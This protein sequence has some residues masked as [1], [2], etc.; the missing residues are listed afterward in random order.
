LIE[1]ITKV[2]SESEILRIAK[3]T[4]FVIRES[5]KITA[6]GFLKML[7]YDQL[8]YDNP[9][10]QQHAFGLDAM[11]GIS[12]SEEGL[13]KRFK[14]T[15]VTFIQKIFEAY[16]RHN[17]DHDSIATSLKNKYTAIRVLDSTEFRLP[18][19]LADVF[20]GYNSSSAL[21]CAAI[22]FEYD[23][24][25]RDVCSLTLGNAKQSDKTYAD[26]RMDNINEGELIIRDLGYYSIDSYEKIEDRKA[27]YISR[28][29]S[30]I[31]IYEKHN[32]QYTELDL[33]TLIKRIKK[34]KHT[35]FDQT[36]Y[37]GTKDKKEVRLMAWLLE[38][39]AQKNRLAKKKGRK[40]KINNNDILWSMLNVF[41]TNI[42]KE[43]LTAQEG[44]E[45]YKIR[46]QI[47]LMFKTWKSIL[48]LDLVRKMKADRLKCYL[49]TKLLW[50]LICWDITAIS[51]PIVWSRNKKLIS[52]YKCF[53]LLK[54]R[55]ADIKDLLFNTNERLKEWLIKMIEYFSIYGLKENKKGRKEIAE[56]LR[57]G[58][59]K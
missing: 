41:V 1:K 28:L 14:E 4:G 9:S 17:I 40:G 45:L 10:L 2:L 21:S 39:D 8:Q 56:I 59:I 55:V 57:Y 24:I 19:S 58:Q 6:L 50:I 26:E 15:A 12:I 18:D 32:E 48:K 23:I 52:L 37:I 53:A 25:S 43:E 20:P 54:N 30:Q 35:F 29:K 7:L 38:E 13:N 22:Q 46:W 3:E 16:L 51:E 34:S 31:K 36:V 27:F 42:S 11:D 44:Y 33:K 5:K 49:Y 47:E